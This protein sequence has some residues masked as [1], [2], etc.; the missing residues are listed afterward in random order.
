MLGLSKSQNSLAIMYIN[1]NGVESNLNKA[2]YWARIS[3]QNG[4]NQ[5]LQIL[6]RLMRISN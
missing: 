4:D 5:G 3:A 1:G 6:S 2:L